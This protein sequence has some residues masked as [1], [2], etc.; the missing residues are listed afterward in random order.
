MISL[1]GIVADFPTLSLLPLLLRLR[2]LRLLLL[3]I[4]ALC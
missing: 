4:P 3:L 2:D 1:D